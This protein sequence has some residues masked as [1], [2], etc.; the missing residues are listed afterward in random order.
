MCLYKV[1]K[2]AHSSKMLHKGALEHLNRAKICLQEG[3]DRAGAG[4]SDSGVN[5]YSWAIIRALS[6]LTVAGRKGWIWL[7]PKRTCPISV[8]LSLILRTHIKKEMLGMVVRAC[9]HS[10][11]EVETPGSLRLSSQP[12]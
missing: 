8:A 3:E 1:M 2:P 11:K 9:N 5:S 4:G 12:A 10:A 6:F 7:S